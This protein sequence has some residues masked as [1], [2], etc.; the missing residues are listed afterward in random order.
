VQLSAEKSEL[1]EEKTHLETETG[2][3]QDQLNQSGD[4]NQSVLPG[5]HPGLAQFPY[6]LMMKGVLPS[7]E[8]IS[9]DSDQMPVSPFFSMAP[10]LHPA[11]QTFNMLGSRQPPYSHFPHPGPQIH[12]E[13]PSARYP[14]PIHPTAVYP[15]KAVK[16]SD[17]PVVATDLQLQTPGLTPSSKPQQSV[18]DQEQCENTTFTTVSLFFYLY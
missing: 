2:R 5:F 18:S 4:K 11:Y 6:S 14:V 17:P 9:Q 16:A 13:R 3:L 12:V 15:S 10:F 7:K 1:Q 8:I